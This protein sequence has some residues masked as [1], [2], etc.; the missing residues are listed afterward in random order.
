MTPEALLA[1]GRLDLA[2]LRWLEPLVARAERRW[3]DR[4]LLAERR[5]DE[6]AFVVGV[7]GALRGGSWKTPLSLALA[8]ALSQRGGRT[9]WVG[10]GFRSG[11]RVE[12]ILADERTAAAAGDEAFAMFRALRTERID[13]VVAR[14]WRRG[15]S[16]V[17]ALGTRDFAVLDGCRQRLPRSLGRSLVAVDGAVSGATPWR[18]TPGLPIGPGIAL[19]PRDRWLVPVVDGHE[20]ATPEPLGATYDLAFERAVSPAEIADA[21]LVTT[22]ARPE[23]LVRALR[24]RGLTPRAHLALA[25]H[26]DAAAV[27]RGI[28]GLGPGTRFS[29][30]L[31]ADKAA[32]ALRDIVALPAPVVLLRC[33]VSPAATL[34]DALIEDAGK[35][36]R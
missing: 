26:A 19:S 5:P 32:L 9:C 8:R 10:R 2:P 18:R 20:R 4:V 11:T 28:A 6:A 33:V 22:H 23:R 13:V 3:T 16:S 17:D 21:L 12:G 31:A 36:C 27:R 1:S 7:A 14:A 29:A 30:L 34:V 25:D 35:F 24:L 15:V